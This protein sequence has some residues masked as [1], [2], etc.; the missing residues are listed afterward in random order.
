MIIITA[1]QFVDLLNITKNKNKDYESLN[2]P[3]NLFYVFSHGDNYKLETNIFIKKI[4]DYQIIYNTGYVS[5]LIINNQLVINKFDILHSINDPF[6]HNKNKEFFEIKKI[7][8]KDF[9]KSGLNNVIIFS[10]K[11]HSY[12]SFGLLFNMYKNGILKNQVSDFKW[13]IKKNN[14]DIFYNVKDLNK[15]QIFKLNEKKFEQYTNKFKFSKVLEYKENGEQD[16]L[17][18]NYFLLLIFSVLIFINILLLVNFQKKL[19]K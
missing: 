3:K 4:E 19:I 14:T 13:K 1:L 11:P 5:K 16:L 7:N 2:I 8:I 9:L 17:K 15:N 6:Y 18:S 12:E 10:N